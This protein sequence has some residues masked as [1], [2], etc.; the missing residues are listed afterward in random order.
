MLQLFKPIHTQRLIIRQLNSQ[1]AYP[2]YA[3]RRLEEV[4]KYQSWD[5]YT[6]E[7]AQNLIS[8]VQKQNFNF[9]FGSTNLAV[10]YNQIL[11]GDVYLMVDYMNPSCMIIGY[12]FNPKFWHLG[13]ASEAVEAVI[14]ELFTRY[15]KTQVTAY[16]KEGNVASMRLLNRLNFRLD[17]YNENYGDYRF[18]RHNS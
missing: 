12:T 5:Y 11:I 7:Q 9:T 3:Y 17:S 10:E 4:K 15:Q 18:V 16:V 14:Q 2:I 6:L 13:F 1:D 8:K